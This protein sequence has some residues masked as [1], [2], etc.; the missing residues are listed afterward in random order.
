MTWRVAD[1]WYRYRVNTCGRFD[2]GGRSG[3][4]RSRNRGRPKRC[5]WNLDDM[6]MTIFPPIGLAAERQGF[7]PIHSEPCRRC[8]SNCSF[9][10][11]HPF[12]PCRH[13]H[14]QQRRRNRC[15][16][17]R[18]FRKSA[19]PPLRCKKQPHY[20]IVSCPSPYTLQRRPNM[21]R[22]IVD[23]VL[24]RQTSSTGC[25]GSSNSCTRLEP[26]AVR[27]RTALASIEDSN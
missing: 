15:Q 19:F 4:S 16:C 7:R 3:R 22:R 6:R 21:Q 25:E 20:C 26:S 2:V 18:I 11:N 14:C 9:H 17:C 24:L 27:H 5:W 12:H 10:Q 13:N 8:C 1:G 23:M